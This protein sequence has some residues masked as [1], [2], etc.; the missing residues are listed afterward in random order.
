MINSDKEKFRK[1]V[2]SGLSSQPKFLRS[3]YFYNEAGDQLFRKIMD[4]P[5]YY[6]TRSEHEIFSRKT[7]DLIPASLIS[8]HNFDVVELGPGDAVKSIHLLKYLAGMKI[9]FTYFPVDISKNVIQLLEIQIPQKIPGQKV[10]GLNGDYMTMLAALNQISQKRKLVLFLGSNI[11]NFA[12]EELVWFL[13]SL[14]KNLM[15]GDLLLIGFDLKKNPKQ[16]LAAYN[17]REGITKQFNLN[18]LNR[19]N[20]ELDADFKPGN[21]DH[22]PTYDPVSGTCIS[23]LISLKDQSVCIGEDIVQ[24]FRYEPVHMELSQKYSIDQIDKLA[25]E[26]GWR[27]QAHFFDSRKWFVDVLWERI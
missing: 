15:P 3:K 9:D 6:L 1:D 7:K 19:I 23:Y 24:F 8:S 10:Q 12:P 18:L 22:Y 4:S 17:D 25:A 20:E 11:G 21:F 26:H 5:E 13:N 2:L 27:S 14:H 16:I